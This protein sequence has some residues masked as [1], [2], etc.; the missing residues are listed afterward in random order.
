MRRRNACG[1]WPQLRRQCGDDFEACMTFTVELA[2]G[3]LVISVASFAVAFSALWVVHLRRGMLKMTQPT[4]LFFG[5]DQGS[6]FPKLFLRTLLFSTSARGQIIEN[7]YIRLHAPTGGPHKFDFW[8]YSDK[9]KISRGSGLFVSQSGV[10]CDNHFMLR[11]SVPIVINGLPVPEVLFWS[12]EY[13]LEVFAKVLG[14]LNPDRL[15]QLQFTINGQQAAEMVQLSDAG[16]FFD[17]DAETR[18]YVGH[19]ERAASQSLLRR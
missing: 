4:M 13:T 12:G 18:I 15:M 8:A 7:M 6:Q 3:S 5:R 19:L 10:V 16:I 11:S 9:D 2:L 17:L 1:D 14:K